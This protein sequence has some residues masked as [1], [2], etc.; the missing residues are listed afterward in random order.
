MSDT[1]ATI[2]AASLDSDALEK[3]INKLVETVASKTKA[4]ADNF[5][6]EIARMEQA[7]RNLGNIKVN[8]SSSADGGS[9]RRT[10]TLKKEEE[11]ARNVVAGYDAIAAANSRAAQSA[12]AFIQNEREQLRMRQHEIEARLKEIQSKYGNV[13]VRAI[14]RDDGTFGR[15]IDNIKQKIQEARQKLQEVPPTSALGRQFSQELQNARIE[16]NELLKSRKAFESQSQVA[17]LTAE[18]QQNNQKIKELASAYAHAT[19]EQKQLESSVNSGAAAIEKYGNSADRAYQKMMKLSFDRAIN[20]PTK[21]TDLAAAKLERL[22][23][24]LADH[25]FLGALSPSQI[26]RARKEVDNLE[27]ALNTVTTKQEHTIQ[28]ARQY[29]EEIRR[30]AQAIRES[31]QWQEKGYAVV[32]GV[33]IYN[34]EKDTTPLKSRISL[35]EQ[36]L[37][38]HKSEESSM[39]QQA[40]GEEKVAQATRLT[41]E[42]LKKVYQDQKRIN[43]E[44]NKR[45]SGVRAGGSTPFQSYDSLRQSIAAVLGIQEQQVKM[46]D[47]ERDSYNKLAST[48]KQLKQAYDAL[49]KSDR[50]S[51]QGKAL[52]ASIHE[53]DHAM[54]KIRSQAARPVSLESIIGINGKGGLSEKTLDDIAYKMQRLASYRSGLDVNV[55]RAEIREVNAEYD[56][57]KKKMDEVMQKNNQMI[58]SNNA[59]GRS[60]NYMK[61]RLAFYFTVGASTQFIKNL[62][63]VRSQY[64]MNERALGILINSAERGTQIFNE[65]SQMALVSPYPLIELSNAAKPLTASDLAAKDV[66]DTTRRLADMASAVGVPMERLTYALGQIKAYG[67]L[68]SRDARMFAN[69]GIPLVRELSKYYTELDGKMVSVGDVYDRMKK[70]AIDFNSVMSVV[71]KMTDEGGKFF[72]FQAKM[73]GTL[74]VQLAN[75]NLAWNNMLNDIGASEQGVL[76]GGIAAL[77]NLFLHWKDIEDTIRKVVVA[78]GLFKV[79]QFTALAFMGDLTSAMAW[80]TLV[81]KRLQTTFVS[82]AS[83]IKTSSLAIGA[84]G[85]AFWMLLAEGMSM[86]DILDISKDF[87]WCKRCCKKSK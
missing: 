51:D 71:T 55:R 61:N 46:A 68:N 24:I 82:L 33:N 25:R 37:Q 43:D 20:I 81:G 4:M 2:I 19:T 60:W 59:L 44:I 29:T 67:Y 32:N 23:A 85:A 10:S 65:L 78:F 27:Q 11:Q 40:T 83:S 39:M 14:V 1:S 54:Q 87:R 34:L 5:T 41:D 72:D 28:P 9:S 48:L 75:L 49:G 52:V 30:Q 62:I 86:E 15:A 21:D 73:A 80:Q 76:T 31:V 45:A 6:S 56:R 13:E 53:V 47:T 7:V 63:E 58:A 16:Y 66:V 70:K 18:Y 50:N 35:E 38:L 84:A 22:Q 26:A 42:E 74:K 57:L 64:E 8:S 69:A 36:L 79:A 3:S 17:S 12:S 77:K